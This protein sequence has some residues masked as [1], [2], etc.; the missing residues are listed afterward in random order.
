MHANQAT[1][2]QTC[3][4]VRRVNA[5]SS[6]CASIAKTL[7]DRE[8]ACIVSDESDNEN[9]PFLDERLDT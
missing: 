2:I 8:D 5:L 1:A 3:V 7:D 6:A 9:S 4:A